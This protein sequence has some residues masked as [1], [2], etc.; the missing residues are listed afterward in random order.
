M[1]V[2]LWFLSLYKIAIY[3]M[4][5][6]NKLYGVS[7]SVIGKMTQLIEMIP[8]G[9]TD[10]LELSLKATKKMSLSDFIDALDCMYAIRTIEIYQDHIIVK[11]C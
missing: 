6:P 9:G 5:F 11:V 8:E 3:T 10:V 4:K 1:L 7:E 2:L